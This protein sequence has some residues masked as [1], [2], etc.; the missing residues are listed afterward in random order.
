MTPMPTPSVSSA[1][2]PPNPSVI[3]C[4]ERA[5]DPLLREL[6]YQYMPNPERT[7]RIAVNMMTTGILRT[8][9]SCRIIGPAPG[10]AA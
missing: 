5:N 9:M 8:T 2:T 6:S 3:P 1:T 10:P 7:V 4:A